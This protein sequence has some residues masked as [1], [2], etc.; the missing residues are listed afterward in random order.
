M[1]LVADPTNPAIF[2]WYVGNETFAAEW[3]DPTLLQIYNNNSTTD[4]YPY[5]TSNFVLLPEENEWSFFVIELALAIP[6]PIHLHGHDFYLLG[7]GAGSYEAGV[8]ELNFV[9]PPRRD[10]AFLLADGYLVIGFKTDNPGA[11]ICHCH[12]GWHQ[13]NGLALQFIEN[14]SE[15]L[16]LGLDGT[17]DQCTAWNT[18]EYGNATQ[19]GDSV[20]E[21]AT[22]PQLDDG[23]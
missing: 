5:N 4:F 16:G 17:A 6:H 7:A 15:I 1:T 2:Q 13:V 22:I 14:E 9:N 10:T 11:W 3:D 12:I 8:T 20:S 19:S 21:D 18:F 23:I